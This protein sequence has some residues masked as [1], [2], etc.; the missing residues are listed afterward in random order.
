MTACYKF[1]TE[2][3]GNRQDMKR[4]KYMS[5]SKVGFFVQVLDV[6]IVSDE[7]RFFIVTDGTL[8]TYCFDPDEVERHSTYAVRIMVVDPSPQLKRIRVNITVTYCFSM[9]FKFTLLWCYQTIY[10]NLMEAIL[11]CIGRNK[12]K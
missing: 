11:M 6:H 4:Y 8:F 7:M 12:I 10:T 1:L 3:L 5:R 2:L 9:S